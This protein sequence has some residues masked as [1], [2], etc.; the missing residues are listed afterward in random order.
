MFT[1][2]IQALGIVIA[3]QGTTAGK[4]LTISL[5]E[6]ADAKVSPGR[7]GVRKRR[8]PHRRQMRQRQRAV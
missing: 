5:A 6:L 8:V 1:G 3:A 2:L 7:F 4:R